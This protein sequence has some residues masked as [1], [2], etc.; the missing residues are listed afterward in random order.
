[1]SALSEL[2]GVRARAFLYGK[3]GAVGECAAK[4]CSPWGSAVMA[5]PCRGRVLSQGHPKDD[6]FALC[7]RP[8][9]AQH[10]AGTVGAVSEAT[11]RRY[12]E[13]VAWAPMIL[14]YK[15]RINRNRVRQAA[16][17]VMLGDFCDLY[18]AA[19]QQRIEAYRRRGITVTY[20]MQASVLT[21]CPDLSR[22]SFSAQWR[23]PPV[24]TPHF[25]SKVS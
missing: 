6:T 10:I 3:C 19:V 22:W 15:Y 2:V 5:Q 20:A 25:W 1:V 12:M 8:W 11:I 18:Y 7:C 4:Q 9:I 13:S 23:V 16:L 17:T 21:E 14:S 24:D